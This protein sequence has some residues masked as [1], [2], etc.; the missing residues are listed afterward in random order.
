MFFGFL[1]F[2]MMAPAILLIPMV[3]IF[4][5][6]ELID[7]HVAVA[8]AHCF[9]NVPIAIWILEGFHLFQKRLTEMS[10]I[11][12]HGFLTSLLPQISPG[13]TVTAFFCFLFS[14]VEILL[15]ANSCICKANWRNHD[16]GFQCFCC[17]YFYSI[18][19]RDF[20]INT[21]C[22]FCDFC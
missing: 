11:D 21:W 3:Q 4:S 1:T 8:L 13:I 10:K 19:S 6:L 5:I 16:K 14:W 22:H 18:C 9:F 20:D 15:S 17:Q 7:T 12:G 2:R